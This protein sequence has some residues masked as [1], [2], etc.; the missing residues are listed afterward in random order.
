MIS[1]RNLY[2]NWDSPLY[3]CSWKMI[4]TWNTRA[5]KAQTA[6][7]TSHFQACDSAFGTL[8]FVSRD[9]LYIGT[10][11]LSRVS[12]PTEQPTT[13]LFQL[14]CHG[15][16]RSMLKYPTFQTGKFC[17]INAYSSSSA[18]SRVEAHWRVRDVF[19]TWHFSSMRYW[20]WVSKHHSK[21]RSRKRQRLND[22]SGLAHTYL[23][24]RYVNEVHKFRQRSPFICP[25]QVGYSLPADFV[26]TYDIRSLDNTSALSLMKRLSCNA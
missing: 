26:Q 6:C 18:F 7:A 22:Q 3:E 19:L 15:W 14:R 10:A 12:C 23:R 25:I 17:R 8:W 9:D 4:V 20:F 24:S 16:S 21:S 2:E 13:T 11:A 1:V 5:N